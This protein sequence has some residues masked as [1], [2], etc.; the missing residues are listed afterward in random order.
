[1]DNVDS[2]FIE[3]DDTLNDE[4]NEEVEDYAAIMSSIVT[5]DDESSTSG[6]LI[7]LDMSTKQGM[8]IEMKCSLSVTSDEAIIKNS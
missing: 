5:Q 7:N 2:S 4:W 6:V 1:M 3:S 8:L